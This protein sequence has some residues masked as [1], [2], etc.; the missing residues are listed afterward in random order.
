MQMS[1]YDDKLSSGVELTKILTLFYPNFLG[2]LVTSWYNLKWPK[3]SG[4]CGVDV[5]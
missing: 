3:S 2:H 4:I 5:S 1:L